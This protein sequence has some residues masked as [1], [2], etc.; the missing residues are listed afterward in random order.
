MTITP[1]PSLLID[2][3]SDFMATLWWLNVAL[4]RQPRSFPSLP[5]NCPLIFQLF[6]KLNDL[7]GRIYGR[8]QAK[9]NDAAGLSMANVKVKD[10][11]QAWIGDDVYQ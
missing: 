10:H 8:L 4:T 2:S 7:I 3:F 9:G 11:R 6:F 1:F 5:S